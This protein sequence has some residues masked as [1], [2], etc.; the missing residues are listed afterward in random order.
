MAI[1]EIALNLV[2]V[3]IPTYNCSQYLLEAVSS[4]RCQTLGVDAEII[5]VDDGSTDCTREIVC[6]RIETDPKIRYFPLEHSFASGARN[7]GITQACG[8]WIYLLDSDDLSAD[9]CLDTLFDISEKKNVKAVFGMTKD[10]ISPELNDEQASKLRPRPEAYPGIL[11]GAS[12][13]KKEV[14]EMVGLF[15]PSL[16]TAETVDWMSRFRSSG[17]SSESTTHVVL[18]RRLHLNNTGRLRRAVEAAD[19]AKIIRRMMN[20]K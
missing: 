8:E 4:I 13:I 14:F 11:P 10:F 17:F 12:L 6:K 3:V 19:Y 1:H 18:H 9:S 20:N 2:S 15:D 16:T 5:I 7:F